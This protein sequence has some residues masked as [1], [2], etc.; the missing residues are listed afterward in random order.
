MPRK[1]LPPRVWFDEGRGRWIMRYG[2]WMRRTPFG[3]SEKDAAQAALDKVVGRRAWFSAAI[4]R[5][6]KRPRPEPL[7]AR[8][9]LVGIVYFVS[10][11]GDDNYPIKIGFCAGGLEKR[12]SELQVGNPYRLKVLA[13]VEATY[14]QEQAMHQ[15]LAEHR[16]SGE[17]FMRHPDMMCAL[18]EAVEGRIWPKLCHPD[19]LAN[20]FKSSG[21]PGKKA[22]S[23]FI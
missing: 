7:W 5:P 15:A 19:N 20:S 6:A 2:S 23:P 4:R 12:L 18:A 14:G 11:E 21:L 22:N 17:W 13:T 8:S 16:V 3:P 1:R 9:K 10:K